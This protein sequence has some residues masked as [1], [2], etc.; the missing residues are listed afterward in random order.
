MDGFGASVRSVRLTPLHNPMPVHTEPAPAD[1]MLADDEVHVWGVT[2]DRRALD[3]GRLAQTLSSDEQARAERLLRLP[4]RVRFVAG[5]GLL[6]AILARYLGTAPERLRFAYG[7]H[8]K[9]HLAPGWEAGGLCFNLAHSAGLALYAVARRR[10]VGVDVER[11]RADF[12]IE[13]TVAGLLSPQ[14]MTAL[15]SLPPAARRRACFACWCRKEAYLKA[16]GGGL[17]APPGAQDAYETAHWR[18][19]DLEVGRGYTAALV[20]EGDGWRVRLLSLA[21]SHM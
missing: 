9:P 8:G 10:A 16:C 4:D 12:P 11:V 19:V 7:A 14:E 21:L 20:V 5:R 6:R 13:E 15:S 18:S 17:A 3:L 1:L 2:L